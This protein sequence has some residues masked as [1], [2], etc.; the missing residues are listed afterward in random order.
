MD[1]CE[2]HSLRP[3]DFEESPTQ[4]NDFAKITVSVIAIHCKQIIMMI[5][6][7]NQNYNSFPIL[8]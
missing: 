5:P 7:L 2:N 1:F 3:I 6:S 8:R 4:Q